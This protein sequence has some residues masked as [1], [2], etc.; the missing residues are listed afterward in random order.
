MM[1]SP[2]QQTGFSLI[3]LLVAMVIFTVGL[4]SIAGLQAVA[5]KSNYESTQRTTASH[6]AYGLLEE[7]RANGDGI[8]TY[9][10]AP[11]LGGGVLSGGPAPDC[12]NAAAP[13]NAVQKATHDLWFWEQML[14]G[15]Q[16]IGA[17]GAAGGMLT[18]TL[19]IDGPAGGGAGMYVVAVAWQGPISMADS[20]VSDCGAGAGK[21]GDGD[22]YRRV[23]RVATFIDPNI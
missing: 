22:Q 23:L 15:E 12:G 3:E 14:D 18:P 19:C 11:D 1:K 4:L 13:C 20:D 10:A 9:L 2:N 5:K 21:Y 17:E 7:M 6:I 8:P 16:E